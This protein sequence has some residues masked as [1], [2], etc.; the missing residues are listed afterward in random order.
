MVSQ[1]PQIVSKCELFLSF[2]VHNL[3]AYHL[4]QIS[5]Q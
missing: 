3:D 4:A 2:T 5:E 1:L